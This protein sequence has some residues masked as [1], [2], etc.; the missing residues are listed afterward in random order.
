M[1]EFPPSGGV[2]Q[3]ADVQTVGYNDFSL[4]ADYIPEFLLC[5]FVVYFVIDILTVVCS[6]S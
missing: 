5:F 6:L 1:F 2:L 3:T 4:S